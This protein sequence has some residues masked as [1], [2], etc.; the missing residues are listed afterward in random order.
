MI[1]QTKQ[2]KIK[3]NHQNNIIDLTLLL[4]SKQ[5]KHHFLECSSIRLSTLIYLEEA[6][7]LVNRETSII[8]EHIISGL[9]RPNVICATEHIIYL[10]HDETK[11]YKSFLRKAHQFT[12]RTKKIPHTQYPFDPLSPSE[13]E[14]AVEVYKITPEEVETI[15]TIVG[16]YSAAKIKDTFNKDDNTGQIFN[17][18]HDFIEPAEIVRIYSTPSY[19]IKTLYELI[20]QQEQESR[21]Q[22]EKQAQIKA[23]TLSAIEVASW[24]IA[25]AARELKKRVPDGLGE[26]LEPRVI[27]IG[28]MAR[29]APGATREALRG[30]KDGVGET[31]ETERTSGQGKPDEHGEKGGQREPVGY[32]EIRESRPP[33]NSD[34]CLTEST[35]HPPQRITNGCPPLGMT[36]LMCLLYEAQ[37]QSLAQNEHPLF[38]EKIHAWKHGPAVKEVYNKFKDY[39]PIDFPNEQRIEPQYPLSNLE[40]SIPERVPDILEMVYQANQNKTNDEMCTRVKDDFAYRRILHFRESPLG[41]REGWILRIK[42]IRLD[43]ICPR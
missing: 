5:T 43:F 4:W 31:E 23:N 1:K 21:S 14:I 33:T 40:L 3:Y 17:K 11:E 13:K 35:N 2:N 29:K 9:H 6:F 22:A 12:S 39:I 28:G 38:K 19:R 42:D 16:Q 41:D 18:P 36:K 7:S 15:C 24:F 26:V 32:K 34:Q 20:A 8:E 27:G 37:G 30:G 10:N 25:R